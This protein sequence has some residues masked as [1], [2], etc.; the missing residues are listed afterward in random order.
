MKELLFVKIL[1]HQEIIM[2]GE[3]EFFMLAQPARMR[4]FAD[5]ANRE[6]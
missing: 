1:I 4:F 2:W 3:R 5:W 6:R